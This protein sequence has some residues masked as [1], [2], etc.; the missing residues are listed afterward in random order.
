LIFKIKLTGGGGGEKSSV[1]VHTALE[2]R[3]AQFTPFPKLRRLKLG[4]FSADL[5]RWEALA[6]P[7]ATSLE[8][9]VIQ[10][11]PRRLPPRGAPRIAGQ[12]SGESPPDRRSHGREGPGV[13]LPEGNQP[14]CQAN[15]PARPSSEVLPAA[16]L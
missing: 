11:P 10:K 16:A 4:K 14:L 5:R 9:A 7:S 1:R 13:P 2:L 3:G 8:P 12:G 6:E 15:P